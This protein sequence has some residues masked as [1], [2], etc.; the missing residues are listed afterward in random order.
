MA[1]LA[2]QV[3]ARALWTG[4]GNGAS[5]TL[6]GADTGFRAFPS[7]LNGVLLT[8]EIF[9][10]DG[11]GE[12]EIGRG[13]YTHAGTSLART[14][15]L[16]NSLTG[17]AGTRLSFSAG[18]KEVSAV[19][20]PDDFAFA[21]LD[22]RT[23]REG[24]DFSAAGTFTIDPAVRAHRYLRVLGS[25]ANS[26]QLTAAMTVSLAP[27]DSDWSDQVGRLA[28]V[29]KADSSA[30]TVTV[31]GFDAGQTGTRVLGGTNDGVACWRIL[32]GGSARF[33]R[34]GID[35]AGLR[36]KLVSGATAVTAAATDLFPLYD[37]AGVFRGVAAWGHGHDLIDITNAG[38]L[39]ALNV[40]EVGHISASGTPSAA[41]F[42]NGAGAW[43]SPSG[44]AAASPTQA[45]SNASP[46]ALTDAMRLHNNVELLSH[47]ATVDFEVPA[48]A[49]AASK[50]YIRAKHDDCTV[51]V[52]GG[53][54]SVNGGTVAV[55]VN[56]GIAVVEVDSN[57]GSAPVVLVSGNVIIAPVQ[58]NSTKTYDDD[59]DGYEFE[60]VSGA[61]TQTFGAAAGFADG[62]AVNIFNDSGGSVS[63]SGIDASLTLPDPGVISVKKLG[64]AL[65]AWGTGGITVLDAA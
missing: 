43:A 27:A 52:A 44:V 30:F 11:P 22:G 46:F 15:V 19:W 59:D 3:G 18:T 34:E 21:L 55:L 26:D 50:W 51:S 39:A 28:F 63:I 6:G 54:G 5:I 36:E 47:A 49:A 42:L 33:V 14:T 48:A 64:T 12:R 10:R 32:D 2:D 65:W 24:T 53:V 37:G 4:T 56:G 20:S 7:A 25:V 13:V 45:V 23:I 9:N 60:L 17:T 29:T 8:Y 1:I 40:I 61:S 16:L 31:S 57:P 62:F 58:V 41:T 35:R 38:D